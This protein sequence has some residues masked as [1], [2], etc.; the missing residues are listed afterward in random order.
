MGRGGVRDEEE[1]ERRKINIGRRGGR[2]EYRK[3]VMNKFRKEEERKGKKEEGRK[4]DDTWG[5]RRDKIRL[6]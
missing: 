3:E 2:E 1:G 4:V 6:R 5:E